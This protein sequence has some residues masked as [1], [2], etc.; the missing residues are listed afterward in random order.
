MLSL[1]YSELTHWP[2]GD[3]KENLFKQ[4]EADFREV[5]LKINATGPYLRWVNIGSGSG[6]VPSGNK[7]LP[8]PML[9]KICVAIWCH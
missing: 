9:T 4:I 8:E 6:L 2:L 3:L 5:A 1:G 7:P